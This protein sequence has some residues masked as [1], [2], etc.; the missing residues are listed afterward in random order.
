MDGLLLFAHGARDPDWARPFT[1]VARRIA[2]QRPELPLALAYLEFMQ[3]GL[4]EAAQQ[5]AAHGCSR[6]HIVP[7][8]LGT[9]GHVRRDIPPLIERLTQQFGSTVEWLLHPALGDQDRVMQAMTDASLAWL[10]QSAEQ[11]S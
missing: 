7:M 1:E 2:L 8:F 4:E 9:G 11:G 5:L 6:I 3:P 10:D